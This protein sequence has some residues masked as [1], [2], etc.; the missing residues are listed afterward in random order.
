MCCIT[1]LLDAQTHPGPTH[2]PSILPPVRLSEFGL[3]AT[4]PNGSSSSA[5]PSVRWLICFA[6]RRSTRPSRLFSS[7]TRDWSSSFGRFAS[8]WLCLA[9]SKFRQPNRAQYIFSQILKL[10]RGTYLNKVGQEAASEGAEKEAKSETLEY[11]DRFIQHTKNKTVINSVESNS[12][13]GIE[14][15]QQR[16]SLMSATS[17]IG[18]SSSTGSSSS[19]SQTPVQRSAA[20]V[21][22]TNPRRRLTCSPTAMLYNRDDG[23]GMPYRLEYVRSPKPP[24]SPTDAL[25]WLIAGCELL[26]DVKRALEE[27]KRLNEEVS[28]Q[29]APRT[30]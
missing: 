26:D 25:R 2:S 6:L 10:L 3:S 30:H 19:V 18:T 28:H 9:E 4:L 17:S 7:P 8:I 29:E 14:C 1:P 24:S 12:V 13:Y 21:E 15:F 16:G 27:E 5:A 11:R 20:L 23:P 22:A